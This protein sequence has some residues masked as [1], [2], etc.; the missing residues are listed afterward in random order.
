MPPTEA[1]QVV[2]GNA[3]HNYRNGAVVLMA[4]QQ[5]ESAMLRFR[6]IAFDSHPRP[7]RPQRRV[8]HAA[9]PT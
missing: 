2:V 4:K 8:S 9:I 5:S 1:Q 6:N 3:H 7:Y